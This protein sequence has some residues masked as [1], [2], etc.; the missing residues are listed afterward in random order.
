MLLSSS[1]RF[2]F[3]VGMNCFIVPLNLY[4]SGV[5]GI[6]Q[7]IRTL[8]Q[9]SAG[10]HFQM[11]IAGV[12]NF[13]FN[14]PLFFIAYKTMSKNFFVKTLLSVIVQTVFMTFLPIPAEPILE[15]MLANCI[16]GGVMGGI[17]MGLTLQ[18]SGC[19]GGHG[20]SGRLLHKEVRKLL[21]G[22]TFAADQRSA[23][24]A[25]RCPL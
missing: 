18:C 25:M 7:I 22:E 2:L 12:L 13:V 23:L 4:S 5:L 17:G 11:D 3:S 8:L 19:G 1:A 10:L 15:D 20:H 6:A 14:L 24:S 16:I 9:Q 21:C